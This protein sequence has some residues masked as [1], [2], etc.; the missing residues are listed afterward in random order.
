[1]SD[2]V[3]QGYVKFQSKNLGVWK[4]RWIMLRM[5]SGNGP[6]RLEKYKDESAALMA[7]GAERRIID[8]T[9]LSVLE[10]LSESVKKHA[11]IVVVEGSEAIQFHADS[12]MEAETWLKTIKAEVDGAGRSRETF[13]VYLMKNPKLATHGDCTMQITPEDIRLLD[14]RNNEIVHWPLNK[15]RRYGV[16]RTMFT[17]EA[18]RSC[19]TGEGTFVFDCQDAESVYQRVHDLTKS[20][21]QAQRSGGT[22]SSDGFR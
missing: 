6:L 11:I 20:L 12:E 19:P 13:P 1:M 15:L 8:L 17:I 14:H 3:K 21:A 9:R 7:Y 18:G 5:K 2:I 16:E 10:R 22:V 4:K